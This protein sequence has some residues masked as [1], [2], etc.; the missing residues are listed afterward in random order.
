MKLAF[1]ATMF[2]F[3]CHS[4]NAQHLRKVCRQDEDLRILVSKFFS[5]ETFSC[6]RGHIHM[7]T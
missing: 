1:R 6:I 5:V 4:W 2:V 7:P 3:V